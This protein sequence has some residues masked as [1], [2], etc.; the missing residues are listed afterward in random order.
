MED[1]AGLG[2]VLV[3]LFAL[4][5]LGLGLALLLAPLMMVRR[6]REIREVLLRLTL[7]IEAD[8]EVEDEQRP[9]SGVSQSHLPT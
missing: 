8:R 2:A 1:A 4:G 6:L 3:L 5:M 7:A 9:P